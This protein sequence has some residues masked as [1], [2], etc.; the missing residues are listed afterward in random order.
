MKVIISQPMKGKSEQQ[1]R[2]ERASLVKAIEAKGDTVVDTVFPDVTGKGNIP[3]KYL[4]KSLEFIADA[5]VVVFM[6]GWENA[7]GCKIEHQCCI[8]YGIKTDYVGVSA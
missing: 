4:A 8:D 5:D 2:E 3:L 6:D 1:V 7:R